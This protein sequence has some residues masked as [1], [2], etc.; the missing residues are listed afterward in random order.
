[1]GLFV[2][3]DLRPI[4]L[5]GSGSD[6]PDSDVAALYVHELDL[7]SVAYHDGGVVVVYE[8]SGEYEHWG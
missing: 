3:P 4:Y 6:N 2:V 1:M 7:D 8:T 5:D